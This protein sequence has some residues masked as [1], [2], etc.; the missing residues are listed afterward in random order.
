MD[1]ARLKRLATLCL[2]LAIC[3]LL[4]AISWATCKNNDR[5]LTPKDVAT[6]W[7]K[8][9]ESHT[10][11]KDRKLLNN[12]CSH[13]VAIAMHE[14]CYPNLR[15]RD[16][17][18]KYNKGRC[19][20]PHAGTSAGA[21]GLWQTTCL[22]RMHDNKN[23]KKFC[24]VS[25]RRDPVLSAKAASWILRCA[26]PKT[27]YPECKGER[28]CRQWSSYP[29]AIREYRHVGERACRAVR[30]TEFMPQKAESKPQKSTQPTHQS[31]FLRVKHWIFHE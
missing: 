2:S 29:W 22:P 20:D 31:W 4:P 30:S 3:L 27:T 7:L 6:A 8:S 18:P 5:C 1:D 28:F 16:C 23:T 9:A 21:V 24:T 12:L 25:A 26:C 19:C 13:A 15:L 14:S 10:H 17:D 11:L